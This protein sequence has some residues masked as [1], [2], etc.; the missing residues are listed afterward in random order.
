MI[1]LHDVPTL[2]TLTKICSKDSQLHCMVNGKCIS[3]S[4]AD[5]NLTNMGLDV[6]ANQGDNDPTRP[7][8][9]RVPTAPFGQLPSELNIETSTRIKK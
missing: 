2:A 8:M 7:R 4:V 3:S 9:T 6:S 5:K 1:A